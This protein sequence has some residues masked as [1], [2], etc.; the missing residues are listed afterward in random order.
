SA[1][2]SARTSFFFS[3][4]RRHTRFSRDWS[5]DVCSSDLRR[6]GRLQRRRV[7]GRGRGRQPSGRIRWRGFAGRNDGSSVGASP[8]NLR[9]LGEIGRAASREGA[10]ISVVVVIGTGVI[11]G[12]RASLLFV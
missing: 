12:G 3:S 1:L 2:F 7:V 6:A 4:G 10:S 5:S 8:R 11:C 9:I